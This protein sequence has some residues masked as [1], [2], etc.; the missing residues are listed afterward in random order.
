MFRS[1]RGSSDFRRDSAER[2][3]NPALPFA[4]AACRAAKRRR[5]AADLFAAEARLVA[6]HG[7][8]TALALQAVAQGD[9]RWFAVNRKEKLAA[10]A[11]GASGCHGFPPW[12]S[13]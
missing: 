3:V 8:G 6:D 11:G 2:L 5:D 7:A 9:A 1:R 13:I 10:A 12:L 4:W